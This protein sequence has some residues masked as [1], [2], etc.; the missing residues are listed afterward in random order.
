MVAGVGAFLQGLSAQLYPRRPEFSPLPP[1]PR[2]PS[3]LPSYFKQVHNQNSEPL[4][5][6]NAA[7]VRGD[8]EHDGIEL[9][10]RSRPCRTQFTHFSSW[11]RLWIIVIVGVVCIPATLILSSGQALVPINYHETVVNH[12]DKNSSAHAPIDALRGRQSSTLSQAVARYSLRNN[13]PPPL[14]YDRWYDFAQEHRCLIDEYHQI[15]R[16]FEPFYQLAQEDPA[17]FKRMVDR[18]TAKVTRDGSGMTTGR[19]AGGRFK[20][21]DRQSTLYAGDWPRTFARFASFMPNM[22]VVLNG[23][24]EPRVIFDYRRPNM[25]RAA[26]N[27]S[28]RTP[29]EHAPQSTARFFKD[30]VHC[31]VPDRP[32]GFTELANDASAFMLASSS[33]EFTTDMY[34][35]LSMAKIAPCFADILVPSEF[36]YSDSRWAP[37]YAYPDNI[38][39]D[40]KIPR[41]YWRGKSSGGRISGTNYRAFPRF[42]AVDIGRENLDLMDVALSGFHASLCD[43]DCDAAAIKAEYNI[44]GT[45]TPRETVYGYKYALDL[46]GN[47]FSGRYLGLLRSGSLVFKVPSPVCILQ[48]IEL[49]TRAQTTIFAEYF[50]DWLRPFEHYIPVLPDLSD[51]VEKIEWAVA[52]DAEARAIQQAGQAVAE[53]V[54]TDAQNDCYFAAVLLEWG[55]LQALALAEV[56]A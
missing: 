46:D 36:Y 21:T 42:R 20:F 16:D 18:G 32:I 39:W 43:D 11:S 41:L 38:P 23:R 25:K 56:S 40:A 37:R 3:W 51:L 54:L 10:L 24:D 45:S 8:D 4:L 53:R 7:H 14:N 13:R 29:F 26:L 31:L 1:P 15:S 35:V 34:P 19:F 9:V 47:S 22:N 27:T 44:T 49:L 5:P 48:T 30:V 2:M 28:D 12:Y 6:E 17:F 52:H 50:N 33:T 55:R